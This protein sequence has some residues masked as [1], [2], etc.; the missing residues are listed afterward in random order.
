MRSPIRL[1]VKSVAEAVGK[2]EPVYE[3]GS[4][5]VGGNEALENLRTLFPNQQYVGCDIQAGPGVDRI[6]NLEQL[7]LQDGSMGLAVCVDT[8]EHVANPIAAAKELHRTLR[9]DGVAIVSSVMDFPI[10]C[11]PDYWRFTPQGFEKLLEPFAEVI[12]GYQGYAEVP[13]TVYGVGFKSRSPQNQKV[14][15]ALISKKQDFANLS[16][17]KGYKVR[18]AATLAAKKKGTYLGSMLGK[19]ADYGKVHFQW[20]GNKA[21]VLAR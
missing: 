6:E 9:E 13:H 18:L 17:F 12:V 16:D 8:L 14:L 4:Y 5:Q 1:F 7:T 10:H 20:S 2:I 19:Y 21:P 3:F 15:D 11:K